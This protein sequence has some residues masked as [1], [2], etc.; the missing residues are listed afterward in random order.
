MSLPTDKDNDNYEDR[1]GSEYD[2]VAD[3]GEYSYYNSGS[4]GNPKVT[5]PST[6]ATTK[7]VPQTT[8]KSPTTT[9]SSRRKQ[10]PT[11]SPP[12]PTSTAT[13]VGDYEEVDSHLAR[14]QPDICGGVV[15]R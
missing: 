4:N 1:K 14:K 3:E 2:Y 5:S 12:S 13:Y 11:A 15:D 8:T 7:A 10:Q 6:K 9:A